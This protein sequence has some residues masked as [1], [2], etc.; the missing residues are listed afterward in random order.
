MIGKCK[1]FYT[2]QRFWQFD[3]GYSLTRV[4]AQPVEESATTYSVISTELI[5]GD[6]SHTAFDEEG[7][8][9][10]WG[11]ARILL[12]GEAVIARGFWHGGERY[13]LGVVGATAGGGDGFGGYG[14]VTGF[15]PPEGE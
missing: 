14:L 2:Y 7:I 6:S 1:I 3:N 4:G 15:G 9:G 10:T 12:Q 5:I 11:G 13:R 8:G